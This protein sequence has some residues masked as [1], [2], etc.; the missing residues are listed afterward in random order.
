MLPN[1]KAF[2]N[3]KQ[4]TTFIITWMLTPRGS[5]HVVLIEEDLVM[6][7]CIMKNMKVNWIHVFKEHMQKSMRLSDYHFPYVILVSIFL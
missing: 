4:V 1:M 3:K 6:V 2:Y 5:N 7:Y